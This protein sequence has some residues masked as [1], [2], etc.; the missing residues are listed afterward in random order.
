MMGG[1]ASDA[2]SALRRERSEL[3]TFCRDLDETQ[4][5]TPSAAPG[6]RVQDVVAHM[7]SVCRAL[8]GPDALELMRTQNIERSN[9][10]LVERRR[11]WPPSRVLAEYERWSRVVIRVLGAATRTPIAR[12]P[13]PMGDLGRYTSIQLLGAMVFDTHTHLRHDIAPVLGRNAPGTDADRMAV[14]LTWMLA[15]LDNQF[16]ATRPAWLDRPVSLQLSGPGGGRW[17]VHPDGRVLPGAG[18]GAA[19]RVDGVAAQFPEWG[20]QRVRWRERDVTIDGDIGY[21]EQFL[22][23]VNII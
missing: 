2:V 19:A 8:F 10:T 6:W 13:I 14:V 4:W 5:Q 12:I 15:V 1:V 17:T 3:L 7:G 21:G 23:A 11:D 22:D 18:E 9:D 16:R 20:T